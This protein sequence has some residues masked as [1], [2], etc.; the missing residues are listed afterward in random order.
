[1]ILAEASQ[2]IREVSSSKHC[3]RADKGLDNDSITERKERVLERKNIG[4]VME[5]HYLV[6]KDEEGVLDMSLRSFSSMRR[7]TRE[8]K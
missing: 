4:R 3:W 8:K 7:I 6:Q 2:T 1:M 5:G